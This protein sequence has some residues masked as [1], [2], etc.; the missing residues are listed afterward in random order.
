MKCKTIAIITALLGFAISAN[1]QQWTIDK[2]NTW[3]NTQ[4]WLIGAN[5]TPA[6]AI[7]QL[8]FWQEDT[9]NIK[10]INK[11][12]KWANKIGMNCMRVYLH[13]ALW[14]QDKDGFKARINTFLQTANNHRI[15]IMFVFFDDC[16][17]DTYNTGK[18]PSPKPGIHNSGWLKD[19]GNKIQNGGPLLD[20]LEQYVKDILKTYKDD[21]RIILWD[22]YNEPGQFSQHDKSLPLLEKVFIWAREINPS[23][24]LSSGV[25]DDNEKKITAFQIANSDIITYHSYDSLTVH[26]R[27]I[28]SLK[29]ASGNR[30]L[31]CTEYMARK[32]KS[33]FQSILPMLKKENIGAINWGLVD[34]KTQTKYA[35]DEPLKDGSEPKLWFHDILR[36]DGSPYE[37]Q[38][39]RL[40][41]KLTKEN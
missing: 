27:R 6:Y 23:Q 29:S 8:E 18:Q 13:H 35:W 37:Q 7:N 10:E 1:A 32:R 15:K 36:K 28:D 19:P 31:L 38:E 11:E 17:T 40:I 14:K 30:P 33:T 22:L 39:T 26:K 4:G 3:Q 24:P 25:H 20:T 2:A 12:L 9:F 21:K 5:Y 34:G 16:W 41:K